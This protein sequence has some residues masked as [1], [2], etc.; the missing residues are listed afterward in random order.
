M[1]V[2]NARS[3]LA[4]SL[5]SIRRQRGVDWECVAV[6]D[7]SSDGSLRLLEEY[8]A[9]D[10]RVRLLARPARGIV[11]SLSEGLGACRGRYVARMDADDVMLRERLRTQVAALEHDPELSG[12]GCHVRIFPRTGLRARR[13]EYEAWL[14]SLRGDADVARDAFVECPLAH[15]T[16]L[17]RREVLEHHP[18][19][20]HGWP[21]DYDLILRLL[22]AGLRLGVV[23]RR[24]LCWRDGAARLSR[25]SASY[26]LSAF[27]A[28]KAQHLA[29][30][31]LARRSEYVLWGYGKTGS[32]LAR[33]LLGHGK[34]PRV[35]VEVHPGRIGQRILGAPV[36]A[37]DRLLDFSQPGEGPPVIASVAR[38]GP[39]A[40][41]RAALDAL[42]FQE[43]R[44]YVCA[45]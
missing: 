14:N 4:S 6:D 34:R 44:D 38:A 19:R 12:V 27:T 33:A 18:Y 17:L 40:E 42:G 10:T 3:T 30:R 29:N 11:A 13:L 45:A 23:P 8:A 41:L 22:G 39:R 7:G 2:R 28:C 1:P 16:L 31:Y 35:I 20:D 21:E 32:S 26:S 43:L 5:E 36:I 9:R 24:L 37:P 15:P 25:T